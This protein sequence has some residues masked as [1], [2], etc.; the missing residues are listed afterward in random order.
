MAVANVISAT[1]NVPVDRALKKAQNIEGA[2]NDNVDFW[3]RVSMLSGFADW[4]LG[5][6]R[7][8]Q[9]KIDKMNI[10]DFN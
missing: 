5:I 1:V 4:E 10:D 9:T 3:Q 8:K 2:I 7:K 6:D